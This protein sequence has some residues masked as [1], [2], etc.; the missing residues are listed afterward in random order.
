MDI[1]MEWIWIFFLSILTSALVLHQCRRRPKGLPPGPPAWP[2]FGHIFSLGTTP[3]ITLAGLKQKYGPIIWIKLC[4]TDTMVIQSASAAAELFKNHDVLFADRT[5]LDAMRSHSFH[6]GSMGLAPYGSHWRLLKK[7]CTVE[8]FVNKRIIES[9]RVRKKCVNDLLAW[10][11]EEGAGGAVEV[12]RLAFLASFNMIGN[13]VLSR[14]VV[15]P[16][17]Q[18]GSEFFTAVCDF[19]H[20]LTKP[21]IS[22]LFPGLSVFDLQGIRKKMDRA[23]GKALEISYGYMKERIKD[24]EHEKEEEGEVSERRKDFLDVLLDFE[25][26]GNDEPLKLPGDTIKSFVTEMFFAGAE[27]SSVTIEW[28]MTELLRNSKTMAKVKDE[29]AKIVGP[30]KKLEENDFHN[31]PYLQAVIK[32]T[33]RLHPPGPLLVPRR[34]RQDLDFMGY[35]IPKN[36]QVLVNVWAIGKDSEYWDDPLSFKPERFLTS[37]I[38]FKGQHF[39]YLPFGAGRRSCPG[40]PIAQRT[41]PLILGSLLHEFDWEL[42]DHITV[43]E[44]D[45][46]EKMGA[47]LRKLVPL[48]AIPKKRMV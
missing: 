41:L 30:N 18:V 36:T 9:A 17:S 32:E 1:S 12:G 31:L 45:M 20:L 21:N 29:L 43:E 33:L 28:A 47:G 23:L 48:K 13:M 11:K 15:D 42:E 39:E 2:V 34:A 27:T 4:A 26:Q 3:H 44:M 14:D 25:G 6:E 7:I 8:M 19:V 35:H 10:V 16:R 40:L 24:R 46:N 37:K 38:D 5:I 22:D